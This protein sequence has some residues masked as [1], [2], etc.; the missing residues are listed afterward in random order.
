MFLNGSSARSRWKHLGDQRDDLENDQRCPVLL[1]ALTA[2]LPTG[3][4]MRP[5]VCE[6]R[7]FL[8]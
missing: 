8:P 6:G 4:G 3:S 2:I 5:K 7:S 1:R